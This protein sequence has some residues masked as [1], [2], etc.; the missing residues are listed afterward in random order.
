[1]I[2]WYADFWLYFTNRLKFKTTIQYYGIFSQGVFK[3]ID[4]LGTA[5]EIAWPTHGVMVS[6]FGPRQ[7]PG[8]NKNTGNRIPG[9]FHGG[10]YIVNSSG[11]SIHAAANGV[12]K[13]IFVNRTCLGGFFY[14]KIYM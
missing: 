11:T 7:S 14:W 8:I 2:W 13:N 3:P 10:I 5:G 12:D 1:M 4:F 9:G 6:P